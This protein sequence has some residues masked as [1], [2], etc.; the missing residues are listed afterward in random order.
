MRN[1]IRRFF[2]SLIYAGLKPDAPAHQAPGRMSSLRARLEQLVFRGLTPET[3]GQNAASAGGQSA[4]RARLERLIFRGLKPDAGPMQP[5]SRKKKIVIAVAGVAGCA[6]VYGLVVALM[7]R[8]APSDEVTLADPAPLNFLPP[9]LKIEKNKD[10]EVV[11][12]EFQRKTLPHQITGTLKNRT[13]KRF[14]AAE[15]SFNLTDDSGSHIGAVST[16]IQNVEPMVS[17]RF[18]IPV[19]QQNATVAIVRDLRGL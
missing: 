4:F 12:I 19:T 16:T 18:Q 17:L 5:M 2:E 9:D 8:R 3:P 6:L 10:L 11:E 1:A 15:I 7:N 13:N 14:S